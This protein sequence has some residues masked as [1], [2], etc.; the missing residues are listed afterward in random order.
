MMMHRRVEEY[1]EYDFSSGGCM[2]YDCN[3]NGLPDEE[4]IS[5]GRSLDTNSDGIPDEC[6]DC[7]GNS[8]FDQTDIINGE[9]DIDHDHIPDAC[10]A[11]CNGN[12]V[13]DHYEIY[14]GL[15]SDD[16]GNDIPDVCD[17]DCNNNG[18][19]DFK[20]VS[21]GTSDD[22][23]RNNVPDECQDCDNNGRSD[24]LDLEREHNL[25][26]ADLT[27]DVIHEYHWQSGYP[28]RNLGTG[29][30]NDPTDL[31]FGPDNQLYVCSYGN[32][33][34]VRI[35]VDSNTT[36]TFIEAGSGG[37]SGPASLIF[38]PNGNLFV[39]SRG[40]S[41]II[42]YDG[43]TGALIGTFVATGS[44]GLTNPYGLV[45]GPNGDL[46]VTSSN[47]TVLEYLGADGSFVKTFVAS[48]SGGLNSPRG[49]AF[50]ADG[51]LLV[52]SLGSSDVLQY[53]GTT[54]A[55]TKIFND[56]ND[57]NS[58][59]GI[60]IGPN[61]NIFVANSV[62]SSLGYTLI[63]QYM[64]VGRYYMRFVRGA[65]NW[66]QSASGIA[67]RPASPH[68]CNDNYQLDICE[69]ALGLLD[70]L[71]GND[72]PDDCD[73][74]DFDN[75]GVLNATDNCPYASNSTQSDIDG[76]GFGDA[77]DNC[78]EV[79]NPDQL[80]SDHNGVGDICQFV[81][82]DANGDDK[83]SLLDISYIINYLYRSGPPPDPLKAAD[84]D[85]NSKINLLDVSK[86]INKLY[87]SGPP[88]V[89]P[90]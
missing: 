66:L 12:N 18:I 82:G 87:R 54:G 32:S 23:D 42:Q 62:T 78:P 38:G 31:I 40:T 71:N 85:S 4:D 7:N 58:P 63:I 37:L 19:A 49:L 67:F 1:I 41:S 59:W 86:I 24:W 27:S 48:G 46:F 50:M 76:D 56:D 17:P 77:C 22:F 79:S 30:L 55:F 83:V 81:C 89:C 2:S 6:Q 20:D 5:E 69:I 14:L 80:D 73:G 61:G 65:N 53:D 3:E 15:I 68:D 11:D 36:S 84:V 28:I 72:I 9:P 64:P 51:D 21:T 47:N 39:A 25:F 57:P 33:R 44:G 70:D 35:N 8:I 26:V 88:L 10:E 52:N 75:D 45:F 60:R 16:D 43:T 34:I 13:P 74:A 90:S 29:V